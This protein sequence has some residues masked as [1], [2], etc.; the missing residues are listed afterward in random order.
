MVYPDLSEDACIHVHHWRTEGF[1]WGHCQRHNRIHPEKEHLGQGTKDPHVDKGH[2]TVDETKY[3][4]QKY[5]QYQHEEVVGDEFG[6]LVKDVQ[7]F[8]DGS[9]GLGA[10]M[11]VEALL[12]IQLSGQKRSIIIY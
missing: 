7:N 4:H 5:A 9:N 2:D 8:G 10:L 12:E 6:V 3:Y 11:L 1:H